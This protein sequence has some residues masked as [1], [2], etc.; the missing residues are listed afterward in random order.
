MSKQRVSLIERVALW[1]AAKQRCF[2]CGQPVAFNDLEI[3][4]IIPESTSVERRTELVRKLELGSDFHINSM[5]NLVPTHH[6]CNRRKSSLELPIGRLV[7]ALERWKKAQASI[8][9][10]LQKHKQQADNDKLLS[11]LAI[12]VQQGSISMREI[13]ASIKDVPLP[14]S[15]AASEPW[16]LT[17]GT[18]VSEL[19][20]YDSALASRQSEYPSICDELE[21]DLIKDLRAQV[22]SL[23]V[24]TEASARNGETLSLRVA[25]WN[26]DLNKL[27]KVNTEP[28]EVLEIASYSELYG[29]GSDWNEYFPGAILGAYK[30]LI[31]DPDE[32]FFGL[33]RCP[34]CI[35][36]DLRHSSAT[37]E[38]GDETYYFIRCGNCG[39][40]DWTQ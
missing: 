35:S 23:F 14:I 12:Q 39:W 37:D 2:Y 30:D 9:E 40:G 32:P 24:K 31:S 7:L 11:A 15:T 29:S 21:G 4:H 3:D 20:E 10:E 8:K 18:N 28:W 17:F 38:L 27:E 1:R 5:Q 22:S 19:V 34:E 33:Q 25:F 36:R 26:L 16:V 6:D 13:V